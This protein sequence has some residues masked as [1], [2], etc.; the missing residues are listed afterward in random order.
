MKNRFFQTVRYAVL[1]AVT[2][3]ATVGAAT[4]GYSAYVGL[5]SVSAGQ[6]LTSAMW[7]AIKDNFADHETRIGALESKS[8]SIGEKIVGV[9]PASPVVATGYAYSQKYIDLPAGT[10]RVS[11]MLVADLTIA[12]TWNHSHWYLASSSSDR[13]NTSTFSPLALS[14]W[15]SSGGTWAFF[16]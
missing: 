8:S 1:F 3:C 9:S 7:T 10:W 4:I 12:D 11:L 16:S 6:T 14:T 15:Q 5:T 13:T 2:F